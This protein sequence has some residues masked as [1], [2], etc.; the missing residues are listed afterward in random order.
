MNHDFYKKYIFIIHGILLHTHN[1]N[2]TYTIIVLT[3]L[4]T[5]L[6]T[7]SYSYSCE[8]RS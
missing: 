2:I 6:L 5:Y 8:G 3:Y 1:R 7:Y 4:L